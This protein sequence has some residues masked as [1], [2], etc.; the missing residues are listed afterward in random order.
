MLVYIKASKYEKLANL[1]GKEV[2]YPENIVD[3]AEK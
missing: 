3:F 1:E 2:K